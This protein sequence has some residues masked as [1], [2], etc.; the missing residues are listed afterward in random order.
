MCAW[1]VV[2]TCVAPLVRPVVRLRQ[3]LCSYGKWAG[4]LAPFAIV[5]DLAAEGIV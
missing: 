4:S 1:D 3:A 5:L 2:V